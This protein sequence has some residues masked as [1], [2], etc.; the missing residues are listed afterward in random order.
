MRRPW[1]RGCLFSL[2]ILHL[3]I[4]LPIS[5]DDD[6]YGDEPEYGFYAKS[7]V[8]PIVL[9]ALI[10][11]ANGWV[12]VLMFRK[13]YLRTLSNML[14]CS[15]ALSDLLTGLVYVPLFI[16]C[17]IVRKSAICIIEDQMSRFISASI[18]CHLLSANTD[19]CSTLPSYKMS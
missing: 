13:K 8:L 1:E 16:A 10:V 6:L 11:F 14:L 17:N 12:L 18:V 3:S 19:R 15:L 7:D 5:D 9:A 4:N 2:R